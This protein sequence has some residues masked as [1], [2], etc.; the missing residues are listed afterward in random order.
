[1]LKVVNEISFRL[2]QVGFVVAPQVLLICQVLGFMVLTALL[3][4]LNFRCV[5]QPLRRRGV[6]ISR[7]MLG[8]P[9]A[10]TV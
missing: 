9:A 2:A 3:A 4:E 5:E 1:M 7:R 10:Q 6:A 8:S